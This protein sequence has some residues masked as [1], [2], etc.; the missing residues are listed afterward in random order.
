MSLQRLVSIS[1][2][3]DINI[4]DPVILYFKNLT[5]VDCELSFARF[6][7]RYAYG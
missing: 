4:L 5:A 3:P 1:K 2:T 7:I 6:L